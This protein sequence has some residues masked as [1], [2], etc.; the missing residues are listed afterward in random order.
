MGDN[1][2]VFTYYDRINEKNVYKV[3]CLAK[4]GYFYTTAWILGKVNR[5]KCPCCRGEVKK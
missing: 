4:M 2:H 1:R 5:N 3:V